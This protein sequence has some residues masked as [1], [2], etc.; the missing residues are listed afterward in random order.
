MYELGIVLPVL[1]QDTEDRLVSWGITHSRKSTRIILG[2]PE[3]TEKL[4]NH[5]SLAPTG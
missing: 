1:V 5:S 2:I 3:E 4:C